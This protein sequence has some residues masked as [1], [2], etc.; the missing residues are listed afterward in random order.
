MDSSLGYLKT[1]SNQ[2]ANIIIT[3]CNFSREGR[4][5]KGDAP[6]SLTAASG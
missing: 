4:N 5:T 2:V 3:L 6:I 1:E